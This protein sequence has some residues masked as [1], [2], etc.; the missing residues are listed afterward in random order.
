MCSC[1]FFRF[2]TFYSTFSA[3]YLGSLSHFGVATGPP[4]EFSIVRYFFPA[5][6]AV[7]YVFLILAF[8]HFPSFYIRMYV[9]DFLGPVGA[10]VRLCSG[11]RVRACARARF[12]A[13]FRDTNMHFV[14]SEKAHFHFSKT[15]RRSTGG[16]HFLF[17]IFFP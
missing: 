8:L 17:Y 1:A 16:E 15:P 11:R 4:R 6:F 10:C 13:A 2:L 9:R 7:V 3:L 12:V 5:S 14:V